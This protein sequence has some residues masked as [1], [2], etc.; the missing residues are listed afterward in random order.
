MRSLRALFLRIAILGTVLPLLFLALFLIRDEER[1]ARETL[2]RSLELAATSAAYSLA[3]S[4]ASGFQARLERLGKA[5]N[6]R[7]TVMD[8]D[9]TV[10][11]DSEADP[12]RMEN[13]GSRPEVRG[14]LANGLGRAERTSSTTGEP[15]R[16]VAI[17]EG[18]GLTRRVFRAA[19]PL[20]RVESQV[21]RTRATLLL[22]LLAVF[23]VSALLYAR[24]GR[25]L[26]QPVEHLSEAAARFTAGESSARVLPD[27]PEEV[28][29][30][31]VT[32]NAMVERL[33]SQLRRLDEAQGYLDAVL[34]QMPEG[35]LVLD[36]KGVITRA[37]AAAEALVGMPAERMAHRPILAVLLSY[38]LDRQVNRSLEAGTRGTVDVRLPEGKSLRV[39]IAPL[40]ISGQPAGAVVLLQDLSE[41]RRTDEMRRDF[42]A[43][44][45]HE[46]RTP[47][48]SIR[49]MVE[50]LMLRAERRPELLQDYGP[51]IVHEC[52]RID[53]LVK[54]LLLLAET[55]SGQIPLQLEPLDPREIAEDVV[56]YAPEG[57]VRIGSRL[58][59][60]QMVLYVADN[61]PGIPPEDLPRIFERF[62]RVD[63]ARSRE[64]GGSGLGL[65]IVRH[66][67]EVQGGRAWVE[68][69]EERG[70]T[71]YLSFPLHPA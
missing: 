53:V 42:V 3:E 38:T 1:V 24:L 43:N 4:D 45:S 22:G 58:Q 36:S 2:D 65:S 7:L 56:R 60:G 16:Y 9:G 39:S 62:Y 67:A 49:A 47:V 5:L 11:A 19:T 57:I 28:R 61:G 27:G 21:Q 14:A 52:E 40:R 23:A 8:S 29:R 10:L 13:H 32:Y 55:E 20:A 34:G 66:L 6:L 51:R 63:K 69:Q 50:T 35:L 44:V 48:A 18:T 30:L 64:R 33:N 68:S 17:A 46:L 71:F 26:L 59:Q 12:A 37:N 31:G 41:L 54:D 70:S 15:L 25:H